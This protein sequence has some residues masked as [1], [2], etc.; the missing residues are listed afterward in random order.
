MGEIWDASEGNYTNLYRLYNR[1]SQMKN[2]RV[3]YP[4]DITGSLKELNSIT[5]RLRISKADAIREAIRHYAEHIQG[6]EVVKYR[7][8]AREQAKKEIQQYLKGKDRVRADE[9][10]DALRIDF[11]IVNEVLLELWQGGWVEPER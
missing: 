10:S 1:G 4:V 8:V 3:V 2:E 11:G 6:L 9:I 5:E 7:E